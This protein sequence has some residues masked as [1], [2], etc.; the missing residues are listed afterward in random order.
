MTRAMRRG[1]SLAALGLVLV[2]VALSGCGEE[3][4]SNRGD[5][6]GEAEGASQASGGGEKSIEGF[7]SEATGEERTV[8]LSAFH[9]S[10]GAIGARDYA[11]ACSYLAASVHRS[12]V[13][14]IGRGSKDKGCEAL[15]P[16]LLAPT[17]AAIAREQ[18]NGHV[19]KV[20]V[21]GD[22]GF[23]IFHAP[24]ARLYQLTM[25]REGGRWKAATVAGSVLVPSAATLGQ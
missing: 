18:A 12:L 14:F 5:G 25:V 10:L 7:G 13:Q 22:R 11:T 20:R 6:R 1:L 15:L 8:L 17:A 23:V 21:A 3:E 16:K 2:V 9:G 19:T 24:G 4:R